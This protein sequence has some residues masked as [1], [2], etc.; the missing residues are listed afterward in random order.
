MRATTAMLDFDNPLEKAQESAP[1][2]W[3]SD[4]CG[5]T[6]GFAMTRI[7]KRLENHENQSRPNNENDRC[8]DSENHYILLARSLSIGFEA[9]EHG[10]KRHRGHLGKAFSDSSDN[11]KR[12]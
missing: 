5:F 4:L 8:R 11:T 12:Q 7:R 9:F 1:V 10:R 2:E 6:C 3:E